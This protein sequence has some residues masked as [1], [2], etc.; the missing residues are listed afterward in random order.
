VSEPLPFDR[1]ALAQGAE[2]E[3]RISERI[4]DLKIALARGG[5]EGEARAEAEHELQALRLLRAGIRAPH[6]REYASRLG[7]LPSGVRPWVHR[8]GP[9]PGHSVRIVG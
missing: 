7:V 6:Q 8:R 5:L 1:R 4:F 9:W 2:R 3:R